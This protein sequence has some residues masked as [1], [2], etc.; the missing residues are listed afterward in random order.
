VLRNAS[1]R[2]IAAGTSTSNLF[3]NI[4]FSI[5]LV[6]VVRVLGLTPEV[7]GIVFAIGNIGT[8]IGAVLAN[9][10]TGWF[11][12]GPTIIGSLFLGGFSPVF[13][14]LA[15][16]EMPIPF[17]V[18]AGIVGGISQMAYNINQVSY[19]QAICPPRMQGRMNATM[20]F[21]VWGTMPVGNIVG[22]IIA[23]SL[24][25]RE[26]IVISAVLSLTPALWPLL[27][28]VRKLRVMPEP[29]GDEPSG[30]APAAA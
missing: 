14:A 28:P 20:R 30:S 5:Y 23:T 29:I 9:R 24:G 2:G 6:Y 26:A 4:G 12:L 25:L 7:I 13:I 15:P 1:L 22:G 8:L 16:V 19:R 21:L 11:G 27:S 17:L 18:A 3:G 10:L